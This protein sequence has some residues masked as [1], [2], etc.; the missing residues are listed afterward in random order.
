MNSSG[1][2]KRSEF[3]EW[4]K[5][6]VRARFNLATSGLTS[7]PITEFSL[8]LEQLEI[9]GPGGYGYGPLQRRIARHAGIPEEC[10]VAATGT[11]MANYLA[12]AAALDPNDEVLIEQPTYGPLLDVADYLGARIKRIQRKAETE[13]AVD[14]AQIERAITD[15][16]R[17]IVLSNLHNPSGALIPAET[18]RAIGEM[19]QRAGAH[20]LVDEVYL[21]MI[22][23]NT[24]GSC[25]SLG[26]ALAPAHG[27]P[28]IVTNSLTKVYGLSGLRC[29]WIV[30]APDLAWRMW[31]LNDLF[32]VNAAHPAE[33]MSA[34]AFDHLE[35]FRE[36]ARTLLA[37]NRALLD[38]FLDSRRD[39]EC[40]RPPAGTVVFPRLI[41]GDTGTLL[42]LVREK[43]ET[44]VVPGTFFEMPQHF[45]IGIG[46]DTAEVG[47]GLDRLSAALDE[48][49]GR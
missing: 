2:T 17:L 3:Q 12:M 24:P 37:A 19:A 13:F 34:L 4:A 43:Y 28:F 11:S 32:G 30:A 31:L 44:T 47:A 22:F 46:G 48:F 40:F 20:V 5:T 8:H 29:G 35:Q 42:K 1:R 25:F 26:Q 9:T 39:L 10:V 15:Q 27:N 14:L 41:H 49:A 45:R 36:R 38:A 16:T 23:E 21:E 6:R 33:Q 7:V 18:L